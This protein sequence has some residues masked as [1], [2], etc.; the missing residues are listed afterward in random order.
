[1]SLGSPAGL[2]YAHRRY[3]RVDVI[4]KVELKGCAFTSTHLPSVT[5]PSEDQ[6]SAPRAAIATRNPRGKFSRPS[7]RATRLFATIRSGTFWRLLWRV[8]LVIDDAACK[9]PATLQ[10]SSNE[11]QDVA[12]TLKRFGFETID[13][14]DRDDK[15]II[16]SRAPGMR[17]LPLSI[18]ANMPCNSAAS[19]I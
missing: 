2:C 14:L 3:S 12:E 1:M 17:T 5:N 13:G 18:I 4:V 6:H 15:S 19:T 7:G 9:R 8:A 16:F 10:N 11:A